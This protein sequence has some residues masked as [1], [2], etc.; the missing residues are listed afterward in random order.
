MPWCLSGAL[1]HAL[2]PP[3]HPVLHVLQYLVR[4][5]VRATGGY[6]GGLWACQMVYELELGLQ[7]QGLHTRATGPGL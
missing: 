3:L 2:V 7:G 1:L 6:G 5:R 4:V